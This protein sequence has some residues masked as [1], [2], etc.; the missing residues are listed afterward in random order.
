MMKSPR[1][2]GLRFRILAWAFIPRAIILF[3]VAL[4]T[5]LAYQ[6]AV[7]DLVIGTNRENIRLSANQLGAEL[8][9]YLG[10]LQEVADTPAVFRRQAEDAHT[11]LAASQN[12]LG[13]FRRGGAGR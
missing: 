12:R 4:V 1:H 8:G 3:A 11:A 2:M 6:N 13:G 7:E 5:F 9:D 10:L